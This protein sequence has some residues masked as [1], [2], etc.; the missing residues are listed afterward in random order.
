MPQ[1][2]AS[3]TFSLSG[4]LP[5]YFS[6]LT[7]FAVVA[8][9]RILYRGLIGIRRMCSRGAA[10]RLPLEVVEMVISYLIYDS[11]SLRA[12]SLTCHSWYTAAVPHLH[13]TLTIQTYYYGWNPSWWP[14]PLEDAGALGFLPFVKRFWV[15][16]NDSVQLG[17]FPM[18][19]NSRTIRQF[20]T[21]TNVQELEVDFLDLSWFTS[22]LRLYFNNLMPT[23]RSLTLTDPKGTRRQ[24]VFFIGHFQRLQNLKLSFSKFDV[25]MVGLGVVDDS[26]L[27]PSLSLPCG[28]HS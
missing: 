6:L 28:D 9:T 17:P 26:A 7:P 20:Y 13:R 14:K 21:L 3:D 24:I 2:K 25:H 15:L 16:G 8:A 1:T 11:F 10:N 18:L 5:V 23:V 22:R 19:F 4:D 27:I 12:C